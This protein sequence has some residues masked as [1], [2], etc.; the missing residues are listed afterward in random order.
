LKGR[1][2]GDDGHTGVQ[3]GGK[4]KKIYKNRKPVK[5]KGRQGGS[6]KTSESS[7]ATS[8]EEE[9]GRGEREETE[10][11]K[12][13][14]L[15]TS[16]SKKLGLGHSEE[17]PLLSLE[18]RSYP[19]QGETT[20]ANLEENEWKHPLS[21]AEGRGSEEYVSWTGLGEDHFGDERKIASNSAKSET[22]RRCPTKN[23]VSRNA[24]TYK[25]G[26]Y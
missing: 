13:T 21:G 17:V 16:Q 2:S 23:L 15:N 11:K 20:D 7:A 18:G 22:T 6:I 10:G 8:T 4:G 12:V 24:C 19:I 1:E 14:S 25:G 9:T 26:R 3:G 5:K